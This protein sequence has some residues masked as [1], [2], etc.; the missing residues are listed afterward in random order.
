MNINNNLTETDIEN[1]D[2]ISSLEHRIEQKEM[3]DSRWSFDKISSITISFYKT[4][5]INGRSYDKITL[6]S[7]AILKIRI[8]IVLSGQHYLITC[9]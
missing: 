8:K 9:L 1:I 7:N 3:K 5:E 2:F 6:R 4:V